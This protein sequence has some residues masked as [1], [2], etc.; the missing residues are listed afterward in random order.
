MCQGRT[1][2]FLSAE[3]TLH[4]FTGVSHK[5]TGFL[6]GRFDFTPTQKVAS[7][8]FTETNYTDAFCFNCHDLLWHKHLF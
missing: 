2:D 4:T 5:Q 6:V 8:T 7:K 3:Q 1:W